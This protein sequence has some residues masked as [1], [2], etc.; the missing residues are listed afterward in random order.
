MT[1]FN[2][3]KDCHLD[4]VPEG[5]AITIDAY[6]APPY[7]DA[8]HELC[9][10]C[11]RERAATDSTRAAMGLCPACHATVPADF[12]KADMRDALKPSPGKPVM[13]PALKTNQENQENPKD[14]ENKETMVR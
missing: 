11:H 5:S 12:L 9:V 3:I 6:A 2:E 1:R 8:M 14:Q 10:T 4:L 13:M 7:V